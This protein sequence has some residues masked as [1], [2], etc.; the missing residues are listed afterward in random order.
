M[1]GD[2][3]CGIW[4]LGRLIPVDVPQV[5]NPNSQTPLER[6]GFGE[7][8]TSPKSQIP[9]PK[10]LRNGFPQVPQGGG[11]YSVQTGAVRTYFT[12]GTDHPTCHPED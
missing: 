7:S 11:R 2:L 4:D 5:L 10:S 1:S 12:L 8:P 9:H 6:I 3:G